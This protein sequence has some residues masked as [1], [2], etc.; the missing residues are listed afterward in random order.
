M[1]VEEVGGSALGAEEADHE[2]VRGD[3]VAPLGD[4]FAQAEFESF[5]GAG[6]DGSGVG[7]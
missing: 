5:L 4:A 7:W 2:V 6:G 1:F 3:L